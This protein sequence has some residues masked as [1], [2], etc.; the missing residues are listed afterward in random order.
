MKMHKAELINEFSS[1]GPGSVEAQCAIFSEKIRNLAMH[2]KSHPKDH[3]A[4]RGLIK[5]VNKRKALLSYLGKKS[6]ERHQNLLS[7]L[8]LRK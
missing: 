2:H 7:K 3:Q 1:T 8:G 5:V 4:V 6:S